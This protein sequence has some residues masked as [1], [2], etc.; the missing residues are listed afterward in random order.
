M[1][2]AFD[3]EQGEGRR[4]IETRHRR[5]SDGNLAG[6]GDN[7]WTK[8]ANSSSSTA[9]ALSA[10]SRNRPREFAQFRR[11]EAHCVCHCLTMDERPSHLVGMARCNF[12]EIAE[13]VVV[14]DL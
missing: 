5:G 13:H 9:K 4:Q 2:S 3:G 12:D 6:L 14:L 1:Y 7:L 11:R 8:V 10:A